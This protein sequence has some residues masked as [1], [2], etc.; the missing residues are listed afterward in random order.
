MPSKNSSH[1]VTIKKVKAHTNI[2]GNDRANKLAKKGALE[3]HI[4]ETSF[5]PMSIWTWI[6]NSERI[7]HVNLKIYVDVPFLFFSFLLWPPQR[8]GM[9]IV[10][11]ICQY[12]LFLLFFFFFFFFLEPMRCM[13]TWLG[14]LSSREKISRPSCEPPCTPFGFG[15]LSTIIQ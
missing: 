7:S 15:Y 6:G 8:L 14:F 9:Q 2:I 13:T 4:V 5:H 11:A 3:L 1:N 12:F 10:G